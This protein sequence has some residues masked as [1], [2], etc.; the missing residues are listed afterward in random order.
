M[1]SS[2]AIT[3]T[4]LLLLITIQSGSAIKCFVC[5]SHTDPKCE[6]EKAEIPESYLKDCRDEY[7]SRFKGPST[8]CRK[9]TQVI[10]FSVNSLPPD[11]RTIRSCGFVNTTRVNTCYNRAGFGGRQVVCACDTDE[12]NSANNYKISLYTLFASL[13]AFYGVQELIPK[14]FMQFNYNNNNI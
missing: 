9:I 1:Q 2:T 3:I 4:A 6:N 11:S 7:A 10:E 13:L 8:Y 5:N 14:L 12:C